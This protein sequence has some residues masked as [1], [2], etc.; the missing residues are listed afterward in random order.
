MH[1]CR[2]SSFGQTGGGCAASTIICDVGTEERERKGERGEREGRGRRGIGRERRE[3][4]EGGERRKRE[5]TE[6]ERS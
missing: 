1:K 3:E 2:T 6:K 5:R 4:E